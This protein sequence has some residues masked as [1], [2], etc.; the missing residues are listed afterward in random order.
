ML[1]IRGTSHDPVSVRP[2]VTSRSSTKTAERIELIFLHVSFL[3]PVLHCARVIMRQDLRNGTVSVRPSVRLSVPAVDRYHLKCAAAT[4]HESRI[5]PSP[6]NVWAVY[7]Y[8]WGGQ[9]LQL[10]SAEAECISAEIRTNRPKIAEESNS[11]RFLRT[12]EE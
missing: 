12:S 5:V 3:P 2:S 4:G 10:P 7:L 11:L 8:L 6:P 9:P 1:C